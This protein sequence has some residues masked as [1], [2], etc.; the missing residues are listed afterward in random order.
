[1]ARN[2]NEDTLTSSNTTEETGPGELQYHGRTEKDSEI[3]QEKVRME[4]CK[5]TGTDE[6][7]FKDVEAR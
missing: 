2:P 4:N 1:M 7:E 6:R 5:D 3:S